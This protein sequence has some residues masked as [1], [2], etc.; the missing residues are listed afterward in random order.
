MKD[1]KIQ[2]VRLEQKHRELDEEI[3]DLEK[4]RSP[5]YE[6]Q[7]QALKRQKLR[8]K[9]RIERLQKHTELLQQ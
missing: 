3:C 5:V 7:I 6:F 9:E 1:D 4:L 2:L 8:L